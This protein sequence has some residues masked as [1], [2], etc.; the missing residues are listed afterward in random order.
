MRFF[1]TSLFCLLLPFV[2]LRLYWRGIKQ[3]AYRA[4]WQE[5]L[6]FFTQSYPE[7]CI[8]FHAV[9]VGEA[10]AAFPLIKRLQQRYPDQPILV[11]TT[12]PTGAARVAE[13]LG[14]SVSHVY[15][16]YDIPWVVCRFLSVFKPV[17]LVVMEKEIWPNLFRQCGQRQIPLFIINAR[18]SA[19]SAKSYRWIKGLVKP[20]LENVQMILAQ[21][22]DDRLRFIDIGAASDKVQVSG[23][24]KFDIE[25]PQQLIEQ[26]KALKGDLF[27]GR[28]VWIIAST[29]PGEEAVFL[30]QYADLKRHIPELLLVIVPRHPERFDSVHQLALQYGLQV[31]RRSRQAS[32]SSAT[33]VY[34]AD[35]MGEL[36]MLYAA[37]D[38]AFVGGSLVPVGGHNILEALA[39]GTPVMFG[40]H[41]VNFK[42]IA[43][44]VLQDGAAVQCQN[45][46]DV[47]GRLLILYQEPALR[48]ALVEKGHRF[49]RKNQ[50]ALDKTLAM[51]E[52]QGF[53]QPERL[54]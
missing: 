25:L 42:E 44:Q 33:D 2:L 24:L 37:A 1:Y 51:L 9:S 18:L 12:T 7:H 26:G 16:P 13:V 53:T 50:G 49:I 6:G 22:E 10:E 45:K 32:I 8:W 17:M 43:R 36:K 29:H 46:E 41:M 40:P 28:F 30:A 48:Q 4:R 38:V 21:T 14:D 23:N 34:L 47:A 11:T 15:F 39:A 19:R 27:S 20:A 35:T 31:E 5:R 54:K 3:A 52:N